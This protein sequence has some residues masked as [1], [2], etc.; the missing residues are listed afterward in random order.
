MT[1]VRASAPALLQLL[2]REYG[3]EAFMSLLVLSSIT[4]AGEGAGRATGGRS[5]NWLS[6]IPSVLPPKALSPP[7]RPH[8]RTLE[9]L[10]A[11]LEHF[12]STH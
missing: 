12:Y 10:D 2:W 11:F 5:W 3:S 6:D 4:L 8:P 7:T 9:K 1:V